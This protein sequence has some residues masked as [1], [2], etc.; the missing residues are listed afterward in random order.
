MLVDNPA[1]FVMKN[2]VLPCWLNPWQEEKKICS[3]FANALLYNKKISVEDRVGV[4][5]LI[6]DLFTN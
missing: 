3:L 2:G 6:N 1:E 4:I 5:Y